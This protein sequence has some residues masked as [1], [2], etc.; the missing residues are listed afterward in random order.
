[1][2]DELDASGLRDG[3]AET[4]YALLEA[5]GSYDGMVRVNA[6]DLHRL[7][8]AKDERIAELAAEVARKDAALQ[9]IADFP[10]PPTL[11]QSTARAALSEQPIEKG[12]GE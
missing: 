2:A 9:K 12:A 6:G 3:F 11:S 8:I 7:L 1:M 10:M 4:L 5:P